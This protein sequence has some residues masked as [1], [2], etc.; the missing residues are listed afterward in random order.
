M[1]VCRTLATLRDPRRF[2]EWLGTICR[3]TA[4]RLDAGRLLHEPLPDDRDPPTIPTSRRS[5]SRSRTRFSS[6]RRPLARSSS[7]ITSAGCRTRRS[8]GRWACRSRASMGGYSGRGAS[9]PGSSVHAIH[10]GPSHEPFASRRGMGGSAPGGPGRMP[11][12][13]LRS[14]A[15]PERRHPLRPRAVTFPPIDPLPENNHGT[16]EVDCRIAS[17]GAGTSLALPRGEPRPRRL[18]RDHPRGRR[19]R[20]HHLDH[21]LLLARDERRRQEDLAPGGT[22]PPRLPAPGP[23]PRDLPG[24]GGPAEAHR[25]HRRPGGTVARAGSEG[26]EGR[27]ENAPRLSRRP[28]A[29]RLGRRGSAIAWSPR[30]CP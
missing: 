25:D 15:R 1:I 8:A 21:Y 30:S 18:R 14:L 13:R 19:P 16:F 22:P 29:V 11:S 28:G 24:Q 12:A 5:G 4:S 20:D 2:P 23:V 3:R 9:W 10:Q 27:P 6:W 17:A 7:S 26:E